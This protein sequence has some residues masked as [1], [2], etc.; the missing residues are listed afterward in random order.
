MVTSTGWTGAVWQLSTGTL[1]ITALQECMLLFQLLH[2]LTSAVTVSLWLVT[3][4]V[5]VYLTYLSFS[6]VTFLFIGSLCFLYLFIYLSIYLS[7]FITALTVFV[8]PNA[9]PL[10]FSID[11][12]ISE[13]WCLVFF[14]I[15]CFLTMSEELACCINPQPGGPGDFWSRFSSSSP[16]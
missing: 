9:I 7:G 13:A 5:C 3:L 6:N 11:A 10:C 4:S 16:W 15:S 1:C 8:K 12:L 2:N 14:S